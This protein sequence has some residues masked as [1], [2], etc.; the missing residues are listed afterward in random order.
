MPTLANNKTAVQ[1][2]TSRNFWASS[3][4]ELLYAKNDINNNDDEMLFIS[5][6]ENNIENK[7]ENDEEQK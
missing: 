1:F 3:I 6:E 4:K 5:D 2:S 7:N